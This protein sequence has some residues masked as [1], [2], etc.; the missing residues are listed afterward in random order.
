MGS[1][2]VIVRPDEWRQVGEFVRA[3]AGRPAG[4]VIEGEPG[5]GKSTLWQGGVDAACELGHQ[6]LRSQPCL[7][8]TDLSYAALSD[9]LGKILPQ[10]ADA[11]AAPQREALEVALLLRAEGAQPVTAHAVGLAVLSGLRATAA[12]SP[13]L[14]AID[15]AHL[16]DQASLDALTFAVRRLRDEPVRLLLAARAEWAADPLAVDAPPPSVRWRE[17]VEAVPVSRTV[18]LDPLNA[19]QV[20]RLLPE[21]LSPAQVRRVTEQSGG[22][23]F[24]AL[25][26]AATLQSPDTSVPQLAR[27]LS[28]RLAAALSPDAAAAL[29]VVAVAGRIGVPK[30]LSALNGR[31]ADP[32]AA[33]DAAI[34]AG[35]IVETEERVAA[36]HPL[37]GAAIVEALPPGQRHTLYRRLAALMDNPERS[38]HFL[39][40]A[41]GPGPDRE[42]AAALDAASSSAHARAATPAAAQFAEQAVL[43]TA[44]YDATDLLRRRIRAGELLF[45]AGEVERSLQQLDE[46]DI[47]KLADD[48]FERVLPLLVDVIYLVRGLPSAAAVVAHALQTVGPDQRRRAVVFALGSDPAYGQR[49]GRRAAADEA[50]RA[51]EAAGP[52]V[53]GLALHRALVNLAA[54]KVAA[55]EG[56][57][58]ELL[59]RAAALEVDLTID[60]LYDRADLIRGVW[61][62]CVEQPDTSRTALRLCIRLA[63]ERGDLSGLSSFLGYLAW[64]EALAANYP[65]AAAALEAADQAATWQRT[66]PPYTTLYARVALRIADGDLDLA[67]E[68]LDSALPDDDTITPESRVYGA[69]LRGIVSGYRDDFEQTTRNLERAASYADALEWT[70]PGLRLYLDSGLAEAYVA[71]GRLPE[72]ARISS[73][74]A[75]VGARLNRPTLVGQAF[76]IDALVAAAEGNFDTAVTAAKGAVAASEMSPLRRE[77]VRS[78]LALGR[79]ER[80]RKA[81]RQARA[82]LQAALAKATEI[83]HEPLRRQADRELARVGGLRA[84]D[85]LTA[86]EQRVAELVGAGASNRLAADSLFISVRTVETHVASIYRKL[87]VRSRAE[88]ARRLADTSADGPARDAKTSD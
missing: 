36:A 13:V 74:L 64:T 21:S 8:E 5:S 83:G 39:A 31:V 22:N 78:L 17:L 79:I 54:A 33:L 86:T 42:V 27:S 56:L 44:A 75:E 80:R 62:A 69:F 3:E 70:D 49:G 48:D 45:L 67:S 23:P 58:H 1:G 14:I 16:L 30:T 35:V 65:A 28:R 57:D 73:W 53:A 7:C 66:A 72:A 24:W 43:F 50:I 51:A 47:D 61:S 15:D 84:G 25:Q 87:G 82:A 11:I 32:V 63:R 9:L 77:I 68:L 41:A 85:A 34:V 52:G 26:C 12:D 38:A 37:I 2:R 55:A 71:I 76:R 59:D 40:L 29:A 19:T 20:A 46:I 4:F 10:V 6:V 88:L 81:R 60:R 18:V